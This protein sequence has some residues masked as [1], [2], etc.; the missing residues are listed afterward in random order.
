MING[1]QFRDAVISAANNISNNRKEI[2]ALNVFPVP[3]GDT[4]TNMSMTISSASREVS[5]LGDDVT[6]GTVAHTAAQALLRGARGNS[7]VILSLI[8][9]GISKGLKGVEEADG[10][11]IANALDMGVQAAYKAVMKPTE[12]TILTVIR[13]AAEQAKQTAAADAKDFNKVWDAACVKAQEALDSTPELLPVLKKA[14]VVDAGGQGLVFALLGMQSVFR[15]GKIIKNKED[16]TS[17]KAAP[18]QKVSDAAGAMKYLYCTE[19]IVKKDKNSSDDILSLRAFLESI[20]EDVAVSQQDDCIKI[21]VHSNDPGLVITKAMKYGQIIDAKIDNMTRHHENASWGIAGS[22]NSSAQETKQQE[23]PSDRPAKAEPVNDYGFV[24]VAAGDGIASMFSEI[25]VDV[26]VSGGQTMNP[27]TEDILDAVEATPAKTV[28]VFPNNKNIV[29]AAE[30][31]DAL[32]SRKVI[33]LPTFTVPQGITAML[34]FDPEFTVEE[35]HLNMAK[36]IEDVSTATTTFAARD[37][38]VDGMTVKEGQILG[39]EEGK[40]TAVGD[41]LLHVAYKVTRHL[42]TKKTQVITIFFGTET[43]EQTADELKRM[44]SLRFPS[45]DVSVIDGG[46]PVYHF[47]ISVE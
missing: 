36:A 38:M 35:N 18:V 15:K 4:G 41:E 1:A 19:F 44:L 34:R 43:D 24:A 22:V 42:C 31:V 13:L 32:S 39:L 33:V 9:R 8:F 46:Q 2:D 6:V 16:V 20:G 23:V 5:V 28:F 29:M 37:S 26:V 47:I 27:S 7:G 14:G 3:D 25:G 40:I 11:I 21:H 30:Q 17:N 10:E 12:G 45:V